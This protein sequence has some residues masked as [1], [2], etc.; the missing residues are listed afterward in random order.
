MERC[1]LQ[2]AKGSVKKARKQG[3]SSALESFGDSVWFTR[4][5]NEEKEG[6]S[7]A[8][9]LKEHRK[10]SLRGI[11][12]FDRCLFQAKQSILLAWFI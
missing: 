4:S 9:E 7:C 5:W 6:R 8:N 11:R 12:V 10:A 2:E 3:H 1:S